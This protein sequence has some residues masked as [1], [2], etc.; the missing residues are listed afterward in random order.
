MPASNHTNLKKKRI[1]RPESSLLEKL[2]A[3]SY[4]RLATVARPRRDHTL[5]QSCL[6]SIWV[7][8]ICEPGKELAETANF[9]RIQRS[10][11]G[12]NM[13]SFTFDLLFVDRLF[14]FLIPP[15]HHLVESCMI[16]L[17]L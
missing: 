11:Q 13:F 8:L 10:E 6:Q 15:S 9:G 14:R 2:H 1:I 17:S 4:E 5:L 7:S 3:P 12:P 16:Y